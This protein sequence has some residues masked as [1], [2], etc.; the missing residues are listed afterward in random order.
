MEACKSQYAYTT[1]VEN[2]IKHNVNNTI[3]E[4]KHSSTAN[5]RLSFSG[6][7]LYSYNTCIANFTTIGSKQWCFITNEYYSSTTS[8]QIGQLTVQLTNWDVSFVK[9]SSIFTN[10]IG[11]VF[12]EK[13]D[14][15]IIIYK[16]LHT[17]RNMQK[18]KNQ[19]ED[20]IK[21]FRTETDF[22]PNE[23]KPYLDNINKLPNIPKEMN[24]FTRTAFKS[25]LKRIGLL[26]D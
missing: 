3:Y 24:S 25:E 2:Y 22:Y 4:E 8:R 6:S 5:N 11:S 21:F 7:H 9:T 14:K 13:Y 20:I 15:L 23:V 10:A 17:K 26:D 1:L 18:Y 16:S 12:D 19:I